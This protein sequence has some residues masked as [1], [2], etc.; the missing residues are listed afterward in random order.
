MKKILFLFIGI[1][2]FISSASI[3][4]KPPDTAR[5]RTVF[6]EILL[7]KETL[8]ISLKR[9][10]SDSTKVPALIFSKTLDN[11]LVI[12][13]LIEIYLKTLNFQSLPGFILTPLECGKL[14]NM[15]IEMLQLLQYELAD[16][17]ILLSGGKLKLP[18]YQ[19]YIQAF[20]LY[21]QA[22]DLSLK[23]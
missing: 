1:I 14:K 4:V 19:T 13:S 22:W 16:V 15:D 3:E 6:K 8:L 7:Q 2:P 12:D 9:C 23:V 11:L 5:A 20:N 10:C 21:K 17:E 18:Y